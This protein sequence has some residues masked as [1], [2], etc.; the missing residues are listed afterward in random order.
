M[1]NTRKLTKEQRQAA[2]RKSRRSLKQK[3]EKL[4]FQGKKEYRKAK[5]SD[6][7][8]FTVWLREKEA[9]AKQAEPEA[10]EGAKS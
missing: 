8:T 5:K 2:K 7:K 1:A 6:K 4:A 10:K 3:W 9:A